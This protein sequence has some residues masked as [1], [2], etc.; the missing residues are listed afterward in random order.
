MTSDMLW[1]TQNFKE[2]KM[3]PKI[4]FENGL[5]NNRLY[6]NKKFLAIF[7]K[8][9]KRMGLGIGLKGLF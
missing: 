8:N 5:R 2:I 1:I 3:R 4:K 6:F 7:K 9:T